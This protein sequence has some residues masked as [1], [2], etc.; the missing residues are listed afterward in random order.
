M[1]LL[2]LSWCRE[3]FAAC[4]AFLLFSYRHKHNSVLNTFWTVYAQAFFTGVFPNDA[5]AATDTKY[6]P[7]GEQVCV[8]VCACMCVYVCFLTTHLLPQTNRGKVCVCMCMYVCVCVHSQ[9]DCVP[10]NVQIIAP[11]CHLV[12]KNTILWKRNISFVFT[13][14]AW[15]LSLREDVDYLVTQQ[16]FCFVTDSS[17]EESIL[18]LAS[19]GIFRS[20]CRVGQNPYFYTVYD[21]MFGDSPSKNT[22]FARYTW[23]CPALII[24]WHDACVLYTK[25]WCLRVIWRDACVLYTMTWCMRVTYDMMLASYVWHEACEL[26]MT[27]RMRVMYDMMHACCIQWHEACVLYMT[28]CMRVMYD[29]MHVCYVWHDACELCMTWCMCVMYDMM[30]ACYVWHDACE[31]CMTWCLRATYDMKRLTA[32]IS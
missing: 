9:T 25:T 32:H 14:C 15:K 23:F 21:G 22:V 18:T 27:W 6:L 17:L 1:C 19:L 5:T 28:W 3:C 20:I 13:V 26:C 24:I 29:M 7:G 8:C 30:H 10:S 11:I 31:L 2:I 16:S 4:V 12:G